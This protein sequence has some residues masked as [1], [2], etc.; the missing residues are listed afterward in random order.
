MDIKACVFDIDGTLLPG[1]QQA[2]NARVKAALRA[3]Q[4]KGVAVLVASGRAPFAARVALGL[5][6]I[7]I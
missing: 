4:Q 5:S 6:L 2:L 1:G 3:L 7:H